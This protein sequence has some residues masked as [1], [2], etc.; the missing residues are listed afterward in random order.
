[1]VAGGRSRIGHELHVPTPHGDI[2]VTVTS[3]VFHDAEG[4]RL[5]G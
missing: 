2:A 4:V 3:P 1:L 5:R